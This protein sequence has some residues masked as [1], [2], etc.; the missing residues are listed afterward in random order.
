MSRGRDRIGWYIGGFA[1]LA[2]AMLVLRFF[3]GSDAP[4]SRL[5]G[6]EAPDFTLPVV[7]GHGASEEERVSHAA[8]R[9]EVVV[10]DFWASWCQPCRY[11]IPVMNEIHERYG[12]RARVYGV[13]VEEGV[14]LRVVERGYRDF[15][16]EF[17]SLRDQSGVAQVSYEVQSIPTV[18][19]IGRDGAVRWVHHGV[20]S[21]DDLGDALDEALAEGPTPRD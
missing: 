20:P 4:T 3:G 15:G 1:V 6:R 21:E 18:V 5:V 11:S 2:I 7:A 13:N 17:P 12:E 16:M 8:L 10:L 14:P 9:G 19:V